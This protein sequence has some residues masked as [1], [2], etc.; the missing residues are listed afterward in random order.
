MA[1]PR[2]AAQ[3]VEL[4]C[5]GRDPAEVRDR[6]RLESTVTGNKITIYE[7]TRDLD[8]DW[9][10][11]PSAQLRYDPRTQAWTLHWID[12][13]SKWH[14]VQVMPTFEITELLAAVEADPDCLFFG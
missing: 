9:L 4:W 5:E 11:V 8:D 13:D 6:A 1:V 2:E 3:L 12:G 14:I 10:R 7:C